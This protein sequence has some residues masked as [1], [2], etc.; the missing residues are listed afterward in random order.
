MTSRQRRWVLAMAIGA[1]AVA[2]LVGIAF[3]FRRRM[4]VKF[5]EQERRRAELFL[6]PRAGE[7]FAYDLRNVG[8]YLAPLR[9]DASVHY[10]G[11]EQSTFGPAGSRD[12]LQIPNLREVMLCGMALSNEELQ[13]ILD[14]PSVRG[15]ALVYSRVPPEALPKIAANPRLERLVL[16]GPSISSAPPAEFDRFLE[17]LAGSQSLIGLWLSTPPFSAAAIQR[18]R[19]QRPDLQVQV[20]GE[21]FWCGEASIAIRLAPTVR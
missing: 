16:T 12:L 17:Q 11:M 8:S 7:V 14:H 4:L 3:E 18:L 20:V 9:N 2:T 10:F 13:P 21:N 15:L 1:V 19:D 5:E 6:K